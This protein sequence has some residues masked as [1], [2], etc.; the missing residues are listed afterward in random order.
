MQCA[1]A[2]C[3]FSSQGSLDLLQ[4]D[5]PGHALLWNEH[6]KG[7]LLDALINAREDPF[8]DTLRSALLRNVHNVLESLWRHKH[9]SGLLP[10]TLRRAL[11]LQ[12]LLQQPSTSAT[13]FV[14]GTL[15]LRPQQDRHH[16]T[17][18]QSCDFSTKKTQ[19]GHG[20]WLLPYH[21]TT[22]TF[23]QY[24]R[25]NR[26]CGVDKTWG[27]PLNDPLLRLRGLSKQGLKSNSIR[28]TGNSPAHS[29]VS[30]A[31]ALACVQCALM[32]AY[33]LALD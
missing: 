33:L 3:P 28:Q 24:R 27:R 9:I 1:P 31:Q 11:L 16:D 21:P 30:F 29:R 14:F 17:V 32:S 2:E 7:P 22:I 10:C 18:T 26:D 19:N 15:D 23:L 12:R 20:L 25:N 13:H 5:A 4:K 6:N 8:L